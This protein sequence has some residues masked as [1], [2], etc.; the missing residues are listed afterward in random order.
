MSG[1][2]DPPHRGY[3]TGIGTTATT[4]FDH[5]SEPLEQGFLHVG[6]LIGVPVVEG[7]GGTD[8]IRGHLPP[9]ADHR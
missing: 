4:E 5:V 9:R 1:R 6:E 3:V 2:L 7:I 8:I